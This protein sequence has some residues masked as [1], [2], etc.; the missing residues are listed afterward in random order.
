MEGREIHLVSFSG[1]KDSTA[2]L[3]RMIEEGFPI[4]AILFFDTGKEFPGLY[5]HIDKI[6]KYSDYRSILY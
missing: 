1:G 2:M 6:E 4:D 3:L 5:R